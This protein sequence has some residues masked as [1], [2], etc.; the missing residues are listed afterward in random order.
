M[1]LSFSVHYG[2]EQEMSSISKKKLCKNMKKA[3]KKHDQSALLKNMVNI[4]Q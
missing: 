2:T 4:L 3:V 1:I